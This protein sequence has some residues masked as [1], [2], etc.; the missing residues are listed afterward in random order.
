MAD[1]PFSWLI[2]MVVCLYLIGRFL[3]KVIQENERI[4]A[5]REKI[6]NEIFLENSIDK[7]NIACYNRY[8]NKKGKL[9]K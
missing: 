7:R 6:C 2:L 1:N 8:I 4:K 5:E 3:W 9:K